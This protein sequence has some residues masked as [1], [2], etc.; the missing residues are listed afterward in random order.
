[1]KKIFLC[2]GV[3]VLAIY[4]Q[5]T[6]VSAAIALDSTSNITSSGWYNCGTSCSWN[7]TVSGSD[8]ILFVYVT[9][10]LNDQVAGVTYNGINLTQLVKQGR[11]VDN[12]TWSY[13]YYLLNPTTGTHSITVNLSSA[14]SSLMAAAISYTGVVQSAPESSL[15]TS[16]QSTTA[17]MNVTTL[18]DSDWLTGM[19][20]NN[21]GSNIS[22]GTNTTFRGG[23][24]NT[25]ISADTNGA[26]NPAG[27]YSLNANGT[28]IWIGVMAVISPSAAITGSGMIN[29]V[30]KFTA[31]TNIGNSLLSDDGSN[32]TLTSGNLYL[33]IGSIVD[34]I[35]GALNIGTN[36]ATTIT[37][38]RSGQNL[39][40]I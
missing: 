17:S 24:S 4:S 19:F 10:N 28:N 39:I 27:L 2:I 30:A 36:N 35:S 37:I 33:A 9:S 5:P 6:K 38:G 18:T 14:D 40:M 32:V 26:L 31:A 1:M 23:A 20:Y 16:S 21:S 12:G 29:R 25:A 3:L 8:R 11:T 7:H 13:I 15:G 34:S 22:A